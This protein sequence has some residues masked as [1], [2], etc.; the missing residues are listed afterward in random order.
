MS[1]SLCSWH[2]LQLGVVC[3]FKKNYNQPRKLPCPI[4]ERFLVYARRL[5]NTITGTVYIFA[6]ASAIKWQLNSEN[7]VY[8]QTYSSAYQYS[9]FQLRKS[10]SFCVLTQI[11]CLSVSVKLLSKISTIWVFPINKQNWNFVCLVCLIKT[12]EH[13]FYFFCL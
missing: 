8:V 1:V 9:F 2:V 5:L 3:F 7:T 11:R 4:F 12:F 10:S 13:N 6:S